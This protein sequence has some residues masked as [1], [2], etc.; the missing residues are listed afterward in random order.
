M[1]GTRLLLLT[2]ILPALALPQHSDLEELV[3][4]HRWV[5][6]EALAATRLKQA[7]PSDAKLRWLAARVRFAYGDLERAAELTEKAAAVDPKN[8]D[9]QF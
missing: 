1:T 6:A 9:Y 5:Q 4:N 2:S 3:E 8:A 7:S